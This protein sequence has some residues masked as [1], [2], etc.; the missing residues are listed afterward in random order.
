MIAITTISSM[1]VNPERFLR[2]LPTGSPMVLRG[3][4]QVYGPSQPARFT[5]QITAP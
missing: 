5:A 4:Q 1:S 3:K 2:T